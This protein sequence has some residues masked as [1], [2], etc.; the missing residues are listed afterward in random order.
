MSHHH[1]DDRAPDGG[2]HLDMSRMI[3]RRGMLAVLGL[4]GVSTLAACA[5]MAQGGPP[6]SDPQP[7]QTA[8]GADGEV[9]TVP[10]SE[11]NGPYP[12]DGTNVRDGQTVNVLDQ[13]GVVRSDIT[14]SFGDYTGAVDG[15]PFEVEVKVV[16]VNAACTPLGGLPF[17]IWHCDAAG[18]YSLYTVPEANWL[19]GMQITDNSGV[20]R[21]T[22]ILPGCYEGR[23]PHFHF[24]VFASAAAAVT[25]RD[26]LL[27]S[28][29]ALPEAGLAEVYAADA[30]YDGSTGPFSRVSL[31]SDNIFADNSAAQMQAMTLTVTGDATTGFRATAVIGL[32]V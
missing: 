29:F 21:F 28:Q 12:A 17:Y 32:A 6:A 1:D 9:C 19:R 23:W 18:R 13:S 20:V 11:T 3:G 7:D 16:N 8:T 4:G 5:A 25:G 31:S 10:T 14:Q 30:R 27:I 22:T 26:S 15:I 2:F 24:E